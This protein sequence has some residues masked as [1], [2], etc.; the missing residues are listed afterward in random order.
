VESGMDRHLCDSWDFEAAADSPAFA[1]LAALPDET[2]H[3][4][5]A[6]AALTAGLSAGELTRI[7]RSLKLSNSDREET[8][9]LVGSLS[10]VRGGDTAELADLK[11]LRA[12]SRWSDLIRLVR[13]DEATAGALPG[14]ADA[15][16]D[17]AEKIPADQVQPPP[18]LTGEDLHQMALQP[19]PE[20]G[21]ILQQVYRAQLNE[22]IT[23]KRDAIAMAGALR[24]K[25]RR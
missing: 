3:P 5:V 10:S 19:G 18:L 17:R 12:H 9:W 24:K 13:A 15:L 25:L 2:L 6:L 1:R 21:R 22:A 8:V 23:T 14:T 7:G 4:S 20:F 11:I 16:A